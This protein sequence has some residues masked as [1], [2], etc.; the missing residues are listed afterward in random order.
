[1]FDSMINGLFVWRRHERLAAEIDYMTQTS[2]S[3]PLRLPRHRV[4]SRT[5]FGFDMAA[6]GIVRSCVVACYIP[7]LSLD[8]IIFDSRDET[9]AALAPSVAS[10]EF[11]KCQQRL[12][13]FSLSCDEK[14]DNRLILYHRL[15]CPSV[16]VEVNQRSRCS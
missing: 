5:E 11:W 3:S 6:H 15:G 4:R 1:M 8:A 16:D 7:E 9:R 2:A 10:I 12:F 13:L 14:S